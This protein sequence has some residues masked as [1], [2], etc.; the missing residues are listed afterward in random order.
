MM[1]WCIVCCTSFY[2]S[3]V[4]GKG[5]ISISLF[6]RVSEPTEKY[7]LSL[8]STETDKYLS[9]VYK[10]MY[11]SET[12]DVTYLIY[13][14][15]SALVPIPRSMLYISWWVI[16]GPVKV[17]C[18]AFRLINHTKKLMEK[19]EKLCIKILQTLREMLEKRDS[20]VEEVFLWL[21]V[22]EIDLFSFFSC[23]YLK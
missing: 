20:F 17:S 19:E 16:G 14:V 8:S 11:S 23:L 10:L 21:S 6:L 1:W 18:F 12:F 2:N 15:P 4:D 9:Q 22:L 7:M 5:N 13:F 3:K